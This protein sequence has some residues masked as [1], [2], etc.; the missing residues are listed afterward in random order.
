MSDAYR[1]MKAFKQYSGFW[2]SK[3]R[4]EIWWQD[5]FLIIFYAKRKITSR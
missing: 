1:A 5:S 2:L 3:N 4:Q